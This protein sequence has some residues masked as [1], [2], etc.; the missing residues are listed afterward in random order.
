MVL[1]LFQVLANQSEVA[2]SF[3]LFSCS[4]FG[5]I[6]DFH[7]LREVKA[8]PFGFENPQQVEEP[9][10]SSPGSGLMTLTMSKL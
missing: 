10:G 5:E 9:Y 8:N 1:L 2:Q 3:E 6:E 4:G 7:K